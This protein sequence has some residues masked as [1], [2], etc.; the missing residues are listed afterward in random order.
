MS[1]PNSATYIKKLVK[2]IYEKE[3]EI[4]HLKNTINTKHSIEIPSN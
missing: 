3:K 4:E 2:I 1:N